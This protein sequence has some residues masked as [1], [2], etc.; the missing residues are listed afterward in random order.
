MVSDSTRC[1]GGGGDRGKWS[2]LPH[3]K[4]KLLPWL[5][6]LAEFFQPGLCSAV[7][8]FREGGL[9]VP[10]TLASWHCH[11]QGTANAGAFGKRQFG[12]TQHRCKT[13]ACPILQSKPP[14]ADRYVL[15]F[16][17]PTSVATSFWTC[18]TRCGDYSLAA[19]GKRTIDPL[20]LHR[21]LEIQL[22]LLKKAE[23]SCCGWFAKVS[24]GVCK[25]LPIWAQ[26]LFL[27]YRNGCK[28]AG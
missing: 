20:S 1:L 24:Q 7:T 16:Q 22:A 2:V 21:L 18:K 4:H 28:N 13:T 19:G 10:R 25:K 3:A 27:I 9:S 15:I 12:L 23:L 6:K 5:K 17:S 26:N 14:Y 11:P 8:L